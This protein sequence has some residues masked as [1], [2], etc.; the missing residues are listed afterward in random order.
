ML[1]AGAVLP[2]SSLLWRALFVHPISPPPRPAR[3]NTASTQP[4]LDQEPSSPLWNTSKLEKLRATFC[5]KQDDPAR[6]AKRNALLQK[7][8]TPAEIFSAARG[9]KGVNLRSH[10]RP[11][12]DAAAGACGSSPNPAA[13]PACL[14]TRPARL[15]KYVFVLTPSHY[16][17]RWGADCAT[18]ILRT[19]CCSQFDSNAWSEAHDRLVRS[20]YSL[21]CDVAGF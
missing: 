17:K 16:L 3:G 12:Q 2:L 15:H 6:L 21:T 14:S 5:R 4:M 10:A 18:G 8:I 19:T 11:E 1:S 13:G 20:R 7:R 9:L